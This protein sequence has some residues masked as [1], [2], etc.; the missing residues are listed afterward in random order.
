MIALPRVAAARAASGPYVRRLV[1]SSVTFDAGG[2]G[3]FHMLRALDGDAFLARPLSAVR[4]RR[5]GRRRV[6]LRAARPGARGAR[7]RSAPRS[8]CSGP[9]GRGFDARGGRARRR[10]SWAAASAPRCSRRSRR[11]AAGRAC[12]SPAS[13]TPGAA[14][15]RRARAGGRAR[16][17]AARPRTSP[18]PLARAARRARRACSRPGPT[19]SCARSPRAC[20]RRGVPCQ[21]ALEAPMA[22]GYGACYGCAV[23]LGRPARAPLR[24]GARRRRRAPWRPRERR[25]RARASARSS[26]STR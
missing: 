7:A 1:R 13:A 9:F 2:P 6:P 25:S 17:R 12:C 16:D 10:C 23:R 26:S 14:R 21:V 24:R 19:G 4:L 3:Q 22:C 8:T 11:A 20:A 18:T 5:R 15:G